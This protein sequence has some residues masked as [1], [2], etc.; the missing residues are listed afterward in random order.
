[1]WAGCVGA[2]QKVW[3]KE[4]GSWEKMGGGNVTARGQGREHC[5]VEGPQR[6][7]RWGEDGGAELPTALRGAVRSLLWLCHGTR[8]PVKGSR[9]GSNALMPPGRGE[10]C[11]GC[12]GGSTCIFAKLER[13]VLQ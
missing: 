8:E 3:P 10:F 5:M 1:M 11:M 2:C 13:R 7:R 9:I 6:V 4:E 12:R